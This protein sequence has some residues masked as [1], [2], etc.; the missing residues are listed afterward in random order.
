MIPASRV[1]GRITLVVI[2]LLVTF[3]LI[4]AAQGSG[5]TDIKALPR[6]ESFWPKTGS[7]SS[8][9]SKTAPEHS[10]Q[11]PGTS[12][13]KDISFDLKTPPVAGCE[14]IVNDLQQRLII[15]YQERLKGIR[16]ANIWGYLETENKGDAAIW[17]AQ[18]ILLSM[19]GIK[20]M[21]ACRYLHKDCDVPKF[22][23]ALEEHRPHS[24]IIM[25]G[26]GN[27]NDYYWDDQ[28]SRMKMISEYTNTSIR[29]FPQSISMTKPDRIKE[30]YEAFTKHKDLQLAARD[31]PSH[32]WL[33]G[34]FDDVEGIQTDLVPD[35]AFM[36]G[37][38][39][40]FRHNTK[41][42]HDVLIL[43]RKD[44]EISAGDSA[45]IA[46]GEGQLDVG[47]SIGNVTYLKVDW[48]FTDTPHI[49]GPKKDASEEEKAK[50][51]PRENGK[52][53]RAWAKAMAGFEMLGS[54]R[55][56]ITDRLHGHILSTVIGV[57]HVLMDSKLGKNLNFH[58]TWTRD[59]ACTRITENIHDALDVVRLYFEQERRLSEKGDE[60]FDRS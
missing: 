28:P 50:E 35:I 53:Q 20:T 42:T 17:S 55:F 54:A 23:A 21:E 27:F 38:R 31:K 10:D 48:K 1:G 6:P 60:A 46:F 26:G 36:W 45:D 43:A 19:L 40:D 3:A 37:N 15:A 44:A 18:Q 59:C 25:A 11:E 5:V 41:K 12:S 33:V 34:Q 24:G 14:A 52:D 51:P 4:L 8:T 58:N 22:T 47:G 2:A 7:S 39:S 30:T 32:D 29:A 57:P 13:L 56:V 49:D 16:Y 9:P